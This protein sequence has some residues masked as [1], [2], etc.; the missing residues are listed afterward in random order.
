MKIP[1]TQCGGVFSMVAGV[2]YPEE[3]KMKVIEIRM[4]GVTKIE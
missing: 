3:V 1:V 2:S 4:L